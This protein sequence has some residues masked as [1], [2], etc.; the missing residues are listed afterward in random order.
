MW[1]EAGRKAFKYT[2]KN[3]QKKDK[4]R[5]KESWRWERKKNIRRGM[6]VSVREE[7]D[8]GVVGQLAKRRISKRQRQIQ[9]QE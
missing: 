7:Q 4:R 3:A 5:Q 1:I 9:E 2:E 6:S 8:N